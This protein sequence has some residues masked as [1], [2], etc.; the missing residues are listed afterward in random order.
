[1]TVAS[2]SPLAVALIVPGP[3]DTVSGGYGYDRRILR[4][5]A[6]AG[7][8]ARAVE[9][10]GRHP[11]PDERAEAAAWQALADLAPEEVAVIDGLCLPSFGAAA[12][13]IAA[14]PT[15][16][17]IH[18]PT[19]LEK[20][21]SE[22]EAALLREKEARL[23]PLLSRVVATSRA[24]ADQL[25]ELGVARARLGVVE[26][27]TDPAPR[28]E[29]SGSETCAI[30]S[31]G[32]LVP[33]KGH[34]LLLRALARLFDLDWH[35]TI[36]GSLARD[37]VHARGLAA[38]AEELA[39]AQRV[40]FAGE[41]GNEA[42]DAL[43]RRTDVFA[44]ATWFEGYGMAVAEALARGIPCAVTAGGA[45]AD[46]VPPEAGVV[47]PAGDWQ[48][49]SRAMRRLIFDTG[50]R[51]RMGEAAYATGQRLPRW[52]DQ[53]LRFAEELRTALSLR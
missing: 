40:T 7:H 45:V 47:V 20:G 49:L 25:A 5:L 23:L 31:L 37:P 43:W 9:L 35:L 22:A 26:P 28:A 3:I 24:T 52:Q 33:R 27:G 4:G 36:V 19:P 18:H 38:L 21:L 48:A 14:R 53:A 13:A 15:V 2:G 29:G 10:P 12:E 30:L 50:L 1:M 11:L 34:D 39:I 46:L 6:E 32:A 51:R 8:R 44:L 17:L 16:G 42:L 41:I